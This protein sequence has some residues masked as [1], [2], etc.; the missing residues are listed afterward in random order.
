MFTIT[1]DTFRKNNIPLDNI[2]GFASDNCNTMMGVNNSVAS[3]FRILCPNIIIIGCIC[4][5]LH[6]CAS[7]ACR[8]LPR[9]PEDLARN[10]YA[11]FQSSSKRQAELAQ[12]QKFLDLDI[13]KLLHPS[14]TRWLSLVAVIQRILEQWDALRLYFDEQWVSHRLRNSETIHI[15]L[16]D[17]AIKGYFM[18]LE[19]V[20][21]KITTM[22]T[23]F[24]SDKTII[25][26]V[27]EK[28][29]MAYKELLLTYCRHDYVNNSD[30][31]DINPNPPDD[32]LLLVPLDSIYLGVS[33]SNHLAKPEIVASGMV[34]DFKLNCRKFLI[35]LCCEIRQR[36]NFRDPVF[37]QIIALDPENALSCRYRNTVPTLV[38][39][40]R[41]MPRCLGQLSM[42]D[43][44]DQWRRLPNCTE[45]LPSNILN[46]KKPDEFWHQLLV[47]EDECQ[48][49][50]FRCIAEFAL[51]AI[52]IPHSN[53][54]CERIFSKIN[55]TK[56]R[57][58]NRLVTA[59][60]NG[61]VWLIKL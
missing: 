55:C 46:T 13:H 5:S 9:G 34:R 14:Q 45:S 52:S 36:F 24:Q 22:N 25:T 26:K 12:F 58:R 50:N 10:V 61:I 35:K 40:M 19:W 28:M 21:P 60:V 56:S 43:I 47:Y 20:L 57:S 54:E 18:F 33:L 1:I 51:S 30:I 29:K 53:A 38:N 23:F 49:L 7:S 6:L 44:D 32:S 15:S 41:N 2:I 11:F 17:P 27:Y 59:T 42:Q 16:N 48:F 31:A 37:S 4:H 3:R 39:L 8:E